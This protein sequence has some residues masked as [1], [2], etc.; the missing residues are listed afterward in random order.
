[1]QFDASPYA[2]QVNPCLKSPPGLP[3]DTTRKVFGCSCSHSSQAL[4][5]TMVFFVSERVADR[6]ISFEHYS[7]VKW[8]FSE[9]PCCKD[10]ANSTLSDGFL[11][12]RAHAQHSF[13][14][15]KHFE[16]TRTS[17]LIHCL[18]QASGK[19][20][21]YSLQTEFN[22]QRAAISSKVSGRPTT[23]D[24]YPNS[25]R[26]I[27]P[28][29]S[30]HHSSSRRPESS[31]NAGRQDLAT[32]PAHVAIDAR[33][34]DETAIQKTARPASH[35]SSHH[36]SHRT[37]SQSARPVSR[38]AS[39]HTATQQSGPPPTRPQGPV[40]Q[41]PASQQGGSRTHQT[42]H[43]GPPPTRPQNPAS[44]RPAS[45]QGNSRPQTQQSGPPPT[46]PQGSAGQRPAT[47]PSKPLSSMAKSLG[48]TIA[49]S[50]LRMPRP[51]Y[52]P[53]YTRERADAIQNA[54]LDHE[55]REEL[56]L[57]LQQMIAA[58]GRKNRGEE[59]YESRDCGWPAFGD[60]E[61]EEMLLSRFGKG[62]SSGSRHRARL[63]TIRDE[64]DSW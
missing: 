4:F 39:Q 37:T 21:L 51:S 47:Q 3:L 23:S 61:F 27:M 62:S 48:E 56:E 45:Q 17:S 19:H 26:I 18:L 24:C 63:Q 28:S 36:S 52:V 5:E 57:G 1:M 60:R 55:T 49:R 42:Q 50:P 59:K 15:L 54:D 10:N 16:T 25:R 2:P 53:P 31:R 40:I 9:Y 14:V 33:D 64:E 8:R 12:P 34:W 58:E 29:S 46:R 22:L 13:E 11:Y 43:S 38:S 44:P 35:R 30:S 7:L 20:F 32:N 6:V 41:R